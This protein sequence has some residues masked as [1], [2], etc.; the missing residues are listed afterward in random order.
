MS[1]RVGGSVVC[2]LGVYIYI[3]IYI[4]IHV[5]HNTNKTHNIKCYNLIFLGYMFRP[6]CGHL[7][8]NLYILSALNVRTVLTISCST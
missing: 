1:L 6:H 3:Y 5:I 8:S 7:Q 2:W 4:Y